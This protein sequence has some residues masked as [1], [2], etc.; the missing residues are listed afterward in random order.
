MSIKSIF[1]GKDFLIALT[2]FPLQITPLSIKNKKI[3]EKQ[4]YIASASHHGNY[5]IRRSQ[6]RC[7]VRKCVLRNFAKFTG[8][9]L[10]EILFFNKVAGLRPFYRTPFY[11]THPG[12]DCFYM[13]LRGFA[14][15]C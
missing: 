6:R 10:Y 4:R 13:I 15:P 9:H 2:Y 1:L 8:K 3:K 5:M 11:K 7:S 14:Y 12:K